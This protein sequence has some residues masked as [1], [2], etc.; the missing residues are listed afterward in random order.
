MWV[1]IHIMKC[2]NAAHLMDSSH[3]QEKMIYSIPPSPT[4]TF[5][6]FAL[7]SLSSPQVQTSL[8]AQIK[9]RPLSREDYP[10]ARRARSTG[11]SNASDFFFLLLHF[12]T[13]GFLF[14]GSPT[15]TGRRRF[16]ATV[17]RCPTA[18]NTSPLSARLRLMGF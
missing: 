7:K 16:E 17:L 13:E 15:R 14:R 2:L 9:A 3:K 4:Q 5:V 8:K 12:A 10:R 6:V 18:A 11:R 1:N